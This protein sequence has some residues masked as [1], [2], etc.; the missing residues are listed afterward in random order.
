MVKINQ[1]LDQ[2]TLI[3]FSQI[4]HFNY[5]LSTRVETFFKN[6]C[7]ETS[8]EKAWQEEKGCNVFLIYTNWLYITQHSLAL[9]LCLPLGVFK[10]LCDAEPDSAPG[11]GWDISTRFCKFIPLCNVTSS[12]F[13]LFKHSTQ[14]DYCSYKSQ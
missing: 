3:L 9:P 2:F 1:Y 6:F 8:L 7:L 13:F 4:V 11:W 14:A 12:F 5:S 10:A